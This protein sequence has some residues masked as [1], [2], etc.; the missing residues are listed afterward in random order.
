MTMTDPQRRICEAAAGL[1]SAHLAENQ[2]RTEMILR[3]V[4][5]LPAADLLDAVIGYAAFVL[6]EAS[7]GSR[8]MAQ[9]WA[10]GYY[11]EL[12]EN[13]LDV[14]DLQRAFDG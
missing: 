12:V 8:P 10:D 3:T 13:G 1:I 11:I 5:D 2:E 6:E 4:A 9:L 7:A 14:S